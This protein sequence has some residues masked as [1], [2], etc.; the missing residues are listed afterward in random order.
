[1]EDNYRHQGMRKKLVE[2]LRNR[3][4]PEDVLKAIGEVPRHCF[5][6]NAFLEL[7]YQDR[8]LQIGAGQ[9]I[10]RPYTVAFQTE[11]LELKKGDKVLEIG[12]GCGYQTAVLLTMGTKVFTIERQKLLFDKT[13]KYLPLL[14][15]HPKFFYG[16]GYKGLSSFAPFD[17]IIVTAGAPI[18]PDDLILQLKPGGVLV[19]PV[20]PEDVFTMHKLVKMAD[21]SL[22]ETLHG[23]FRFVPM[24]EEKEWG[25]R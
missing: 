2:E 4:I 11:L 12:T 22:Q 3:G 18:I 19:I 5:L 14:G 7:A 23:T 16:D 20:G 9:T 1:M 15:F 24:L 6:E 25:K 8:A 17:K 21:G 10:S 13:Q